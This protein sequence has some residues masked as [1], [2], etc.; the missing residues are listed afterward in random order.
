[1]QKISNF[2]ALVILAAA[3]FFQI[4][5]IDP[6]KDEL[7]T[8]NVRLETDADGLNP[9]LTNNSNSIQVFQKIFLTMADFEPKTLEL[10]PLLIK[11]LPVETAVD[12]GVFKGG[13]RFDL[14]SY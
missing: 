4:G 1:M 5:C 10:K 12:T 2:F 6:K 11:N 7:K 14:R 3:L 13:Y 8:L 9:F